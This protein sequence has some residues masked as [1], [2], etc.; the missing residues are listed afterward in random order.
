MHSV[1]TPSRSIPVTPPMTQSSTPS[2]S[3]TSPSPTPTTASNCSAFRPIACAPGKRKKKV[4]Q[5]DNLIQVALAKLENEKEQDQFMAFGVVVG[6]KLK[7]MDKFQSTVAE[8]I[9]NDVLFL[10]TLN[11][12]TEDHHITK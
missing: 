1:P 2:P 3:S 9:I 4:D 12:L 11:R 10:G 6:S 5:T 7:N 8:K